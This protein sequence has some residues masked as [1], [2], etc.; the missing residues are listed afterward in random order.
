MTIDV[1][2]DDIVTRRFLGCVLGSVEFSVAPGEVL[3][4]SLDITGKKEESGTAQTPVFTG[5]P[6]FAEHQ[7]SV[8]LG[9][10]AVKPRAL[11]LSISNELEPLE[12]VGDRYYASIPVKGLTVEGSMDLL[13]ENT[14]QLDRFLNGAETSLTVEFTGAEIESGFS[15]MLKFELPRIIYKTHEAGI[16][17]RELLVESID[18]EALYDATAGYLIRVQLQNTE[19]GY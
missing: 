10:I 8:T 14:S 16:D 5:L 6:P 11:S 1:C 12:V 2:M 7:A 9:G 15:Y 17:R 3:A 13:F 4:A 19:S 18:F